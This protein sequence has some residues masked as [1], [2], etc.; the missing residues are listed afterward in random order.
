MSMNIELKP[1]PGPTSAT[2]F[3]IDTATRS[4]LEA[5][6]DELNMSMSEVLCELVNQYY[7]LTHAEGL[8]AQKN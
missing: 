3:R 1:K 8:T 7:D 2:T 6:A 4:K 5:L